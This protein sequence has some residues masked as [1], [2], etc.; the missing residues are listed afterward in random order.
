MRFL[1]SYII[2]KDSETISISLRKIQAAAQADM[3][4]LIEQ[5]DVIPTD[6]DTRI[7]KLNIKFNTVSQRIGLQNDFAARVATGIDGIIKNKLR[8]LR[9]VESNS[10]KAISSDGVQGDLR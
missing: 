3:L 10:T 1:L 9:V 4:A 5:E 7:S 2:T 6:M 8:I